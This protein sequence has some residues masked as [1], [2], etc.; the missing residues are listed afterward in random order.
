[1]FEGTWERAKRVV[2]VKYLLETFK[3]FLK[4]LKVLHLDS[5]DQQYIWITAPRTYGRAIFSAADTRCSE[6]PTWSQNEARVSFK[7]RLT[8]AELL[9]VTLAPC[10]KLSLSNLASAPPRR[11]PENNSTGLDEPATGEPC[12]R[13]TELHK[14]LAQSEGKHA[15]LLGSKATKQ[16]KPDAFKSFF[17]YYIFAQCEYF[18][19]TPNTNRYK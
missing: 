2:T 8:E 17:L 16:Q 9:N 12:V 18:Y 14:G 5:K 13:G 15:G 6:N 19:W 10:A 11:A 4:M 3:T 7:V 1:M